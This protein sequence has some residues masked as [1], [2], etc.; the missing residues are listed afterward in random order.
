MDLQ[1]TDD[2]SLQLN[3]NFIFL[4]TSAIF[5]YLNKVPVF[6]AFSCHNHLPFS[7]VLIS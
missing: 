2:G 4:N 3:F 7:V 5:I 6:F 1:P